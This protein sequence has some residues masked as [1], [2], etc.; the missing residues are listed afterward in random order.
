M[1][2][3]KIGRYKILGELGRGAMG[4]VYRAF[5]PNI[6]REVALKTIHLDR[7]DPQMIERF[8][9]EAQTAGTL[10]HPNIVTIYDADEDNGVFYIAMELLQGETLQQIVAGGALPVEQII[11]IVEQIGNA[12]DYAHARTVVHRDIKPANIMVFEGH[13]KVMD[14]GLAKIASSRLTNTGLVAGTPAYMSPEQAK[15]LT[16]DGRSDIFSLGTIMY[17]MLTGVMPFRAEHLTAVVFKVV[18]EEPLPPTTVN[19]MLHPGLNRVVIKA[20]AKDPARRYQRCEELIAELKNYA[21]L[22][23]EKPTPVPPSKRIP[24]VA[25]PSVVR[26]TPRWKRGVVAVA[27][28]VLLMAGIGLYLQLRRGPESPTTVPTEQ[29]VAAPALAPPPTASPPAAPAS[30]PSAAPPSP[31]S[32]AGSQ[33]VRSPA[34]GAPASS[35]AAQPSRSAAESKPPQPARSL[36]S[37]AA[38]GRQVPAGP[39]AAG[40]EGRVVVHT[41][42][43]GAKILVDGEET[44]YRTPV[45]FGLSA[46]RHRI[47]VE[48]SGFESETQEIVVRQD[49]TVQ[50]QLDLKPTGERRRLLPFRR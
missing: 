17:E 8:R 15:G 1:I 27:G 34:P 3:E 21:A 28:G 42:P 29:P 18:T 33:P 41:Q 2:P 37:R 26:A 46:G 4:V 19:S 7:Q 44:A 13:V 32:P 38:P 39:P 30:P 49:Q 45:N 20:M 16:V 9:R 43:E 50:V 10:S 23:T 11:P 40:V 35:S 6:G 22:G 24:E 36:P 31:G 47:T 25:A 48:R 5:D 14:F 12:L